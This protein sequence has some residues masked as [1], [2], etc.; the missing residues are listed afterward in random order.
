MRWRKGVHLP[1]IQGLL[2]PRCISVPKSASAQD[3]DEGDAVEESTGIEGH[4]DG[5]EEKGEGEHE[6]DSEECEEEF[7]EFEEQ[8]G[9]ECDEE[10]GSMRRSMRRGVRG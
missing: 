2:G 9:E 7:D 1:L 4:A 5:D 10:Q 8:S 3:R 6:V